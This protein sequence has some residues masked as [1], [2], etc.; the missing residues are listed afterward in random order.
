MANRRKYTIICA[1][2]VF[3]TLI[4]I[5]IAYINHKTSN[6][7]IS[8]YSIVGF[9]NSG[10]E[11]SFSIDIQGEYAYFANDILDN[12]K[13]CYET[14]YSKNEFYVIYF[15]CNDIEFDSSATV[16]LLNSNKSDINAERVFSPT[17]IYQ[18]T[19]FK[20]I[21][22]SD[23][24]GRI[25][26][27]VAF[28]NVKKA[29]VHV[30]IKPIIEDEEYW[31][32][33]SKDNSV[34]MVF[35]SYDIEK[36][37]LESDIISNWVDKYTSLRS[38]FLS[39]SGGREPYCGTTDYVLTEKFD[40]LGLAGDPIYINQNCVREMLTTINS[41]QTDNT[42]LSWEL[43]HEMS[44]TFDG[45][46]GSNIDNIWN[47]DSE[48]FADLKMV[49]VLDKNAYYTE[50]SF[51][52]YLSTLKRMNTLDNGVYTSQGF[53]YLFLSTIRE[54]DNC[55]LEHIKNLFEI[56]VNNFKLNGINDNQFSAFESAF[57]DEYGVPLQYFLTENEYET[58]K[59][60]YHTK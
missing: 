58:L 2:F 30:K 46:E 51:E 52:E 27:D 33:S 8:P 47:F 36:S 32:F 54:I 14:H 31:I 45:I 56:M 48:F 25:K 59:S 35:L 57:L 10:D 29:G 13:L 38:D 41:N 21:V 1:V 39:L 60:K 55:Y 28:F 6:T 9:D 24:E 22:K 15:D 40:F 34:R 44:H 26:F 42:D 3:I 50:K 20:Q 53:T 5:T 11:I 18:H 12:T 4:A 43:V 49:Y 37:R 16:T 23:A 7:T 19:S 17:N